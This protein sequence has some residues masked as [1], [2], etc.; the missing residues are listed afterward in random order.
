[1]IQ[2]A[3]LRFRS[4]IRFGDEFTRRRYYERVWLPAVKAQ[5]APFA[6]APGVRIRVNERLVLQPGETVSPRVFEQADR[7]EVNLYDLIESGHII[8]KRDPP[9][10]AA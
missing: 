2:Q 1:M 10:D 8:E 9:K 3:I 5:T 7:P 6:V 4:P